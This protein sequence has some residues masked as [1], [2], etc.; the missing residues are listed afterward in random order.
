MSSSPAANPGVLVKD[1]N[2]PRPGGGCFFEELLTVSLKV[3]FMKSGTCFSRSRG[4]GLLE[5]ILVFAIVIGAAAVVFSIFQSAQPSADAANEASVLTT[6]VAN[7]RQAYGGNYAVIVQS[8]VIK[9][10]AAP[11]S[12]VSGGTGL[13]SQWGTVTVG[14]AGGADPHHFWVTYANVPTDVCTKLVSGVAAYFPAG[15]KVG[16]TAVMDSQG[17]L[18]SGQPMAACGLA[19]TAKIVFTAG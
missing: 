15:I 12:M 7:T 9:A 17:Q 18:L 19:T 13:V 8:D 4:F 5:V 16:T 14:R 11:A 10:Q 2:N 3:S 6:L 1:P